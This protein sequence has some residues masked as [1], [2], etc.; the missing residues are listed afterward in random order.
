MTV[1]KIV[2]CDDTT[3]ITE[4]DWGMTFSAEELEIIGKLADLS[5]KIQCYY[6]M[7]VIEI[8]EREEEDD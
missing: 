1:I 3:Y 8:T 2:G 7:P 5:K 6:C 4:N